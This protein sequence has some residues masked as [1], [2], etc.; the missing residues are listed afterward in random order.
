M[1]EQID[2][3]LGRAFV[4]ACYCTGV[5]GLLASPA[6]RRAVAARAVNPARGMVRRIRP[7]GTKSPVWKLFRSGVV[8]MV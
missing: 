2:V 4:K 6:T 3:L 5:A 1:A 7:R 8:M